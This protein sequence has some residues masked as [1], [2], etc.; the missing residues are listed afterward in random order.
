[1]RRLDLL[2]LHPKQFLFKTNKTR[3]TTI[4]NRSDQSG[5]NDGHWLALACGGANGRDGQH[6]TLEGIRKWPELLH[7]AGKTL[8]ITKKTR[9][10]HVEEEGEIRKGERVRG[11]S[12]REP[13]PPRYIMLLLLD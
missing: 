8:K 1:L 10:K 11:E 13:L 5:G 4:K 6:N 12:R 2:L 3:N 7:M 9:E